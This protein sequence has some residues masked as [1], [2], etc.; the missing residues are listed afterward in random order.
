MIMPQESQRV[1]TLE[2]R[3]RQQKGHIRTM[4]QQVKK[5]KRKRIVVT[6]NSSA[7]QRQRRRRIAVDSIIN[8]AY[9]IGLLFGGSMEEGNLMEKIAEGMIGC[10]MYLIMHHTILQLCYH[11]SL[12]T[13]I[14]YYQ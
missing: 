1:G 11:P 12:H 2:E 10:I 4:E 7:T 6:S 5:L 3:V 14:S 13:S 8:T 9:D